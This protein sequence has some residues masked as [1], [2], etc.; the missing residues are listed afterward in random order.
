MANETRNVFQAATSITVTNLAGLSGSNQDIW[1]SA[2]ISADAGSGKIYPGVKIWYDIDWSATPAA[3]DLITFRIAEGSEHAT[4]I[5]PGDI[6]EGTDA[7]ITTAGPKDNIRDNI[8]IAHRVVMRG[9]NYS[10]NIKGVFSYFD[11]AKD[12][13]LLVGVQTT[14][15]TIH[16]TAGN[17]AI[18]YRYF[19]PQGQ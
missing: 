6:S 5:W 17:L 3:G 9:T 10:T 18:Q 12:W 19:E 11:I 16:A 15:V 4:E 1:R 14:S 8:P 7:K 13:M 2:V